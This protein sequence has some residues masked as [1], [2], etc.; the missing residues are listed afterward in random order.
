MSK[1]TSIWRWQMARH[2]QVTNHAIS[3]SSTNACMWPCSTRRAPWVSPA[4]KSTHPHCI[5]NTHIEGVSR[6]TVVVLGLNKNNNIQRCKAYIGLQTV[7]HWASSFY[8]SI[9]KPLQLYAVNN[10]IFYYTKCDYGTPLADRP[11]GRPPN[12]PHHPPPFNTRFHKYRI[13]SNFGRI[14]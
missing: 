5:Y 7:S 14:C 8:I 9:Q 11:S 4:S 3:S 12:Y 10:I 13:K 2:G 1:Y 6:C